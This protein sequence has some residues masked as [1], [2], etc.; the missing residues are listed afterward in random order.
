ME[1]RWAIQSLESAAL[2]LRT[3]GR[4]VYL[5]KGLKTEMALEN[6]T[7]FLDSILINMHDR[8]VQLD[9]N[10]ANKMLNCY[11][12]TGRTGRALHFFYRLGKDYVGKG[13]LFENEG[14]LPHDE[15]G[16]FRIRMKMNHPPPAYKVPG[17]SMKDKRG[18]NHIS[19]LKESVS[20]TFVNFCFFNFCFFNF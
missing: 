13:A 11:S 1:F 9:I 2:H 19:N 14:K 8:G 16:E 15:Y 18:R 10:T 20:V 6:P 3:W 4:N 17:Q 5:G 7:R 12:C